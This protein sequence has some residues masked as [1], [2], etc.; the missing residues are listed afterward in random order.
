ML[1]HFLDAGKVSIV[2][3]VLNKLGFC[4]FNIGNELKA[5]H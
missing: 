5:I 2:K 1:M 3:L 4:F